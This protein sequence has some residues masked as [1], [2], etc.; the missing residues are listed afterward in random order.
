MRGFAAVLLIAFALPAA[1]ADEYPLKVYVLGSSE[2]SREIKRMWPDPCIKAALGAPC[3]DYEEL[4]PPGWSV[5]I[6]QVTARMTH[7]GRTTQYELVCKTIS[8]RRP[9]APM[10]YGAYAAR[11]KGKKLE[12]LVTT[13][14]GKGT[15]NH[16]EI[17]GERSAD[18]EVY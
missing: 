16:F 2:T 18:D 5:D 9:C 13:G 3:R 12:V 10:Q 15:V 1:A 8:P 7:R 4:P 14:K 6:L 11:W 17:K